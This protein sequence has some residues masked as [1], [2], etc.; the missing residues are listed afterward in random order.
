MKKEFINPEVEIIKVETTVEIMTTSA[1]KA[2]LIGGF[3][4]GLDQ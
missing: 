4:F 1:D 2:S 3:D